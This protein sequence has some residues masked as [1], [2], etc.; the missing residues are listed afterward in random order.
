ML[1]RSVRSQCGTHAQLMAMP[2]PTAPGAV[3]YRT[4]AARLEDAARVAQEE[5]AEAETQALPEDG[6]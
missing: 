1:V 6:T 5:A 3:T 2:L 4:L